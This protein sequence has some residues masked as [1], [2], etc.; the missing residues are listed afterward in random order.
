FKPIFS[1][2][3][4]RIA[5][6]IKSIKAR[7]NERRHKTRSFNAILSQAHESFCNLEPGFLVFS[8]AVASNSNRIVRPPHP[9]RR[10][11]LIPF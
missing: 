7:S 4:D 9:T 5:D 8:E 1:S 2:K 3:A 6:R 10:L 11:H